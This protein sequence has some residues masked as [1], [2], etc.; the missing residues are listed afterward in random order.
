[1]VPKTCNFRSSKKKTK[2]DFFPKCLLYFVI[3]Y[4]K[5]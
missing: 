4:I 5:K 3:K 2:N 1:M